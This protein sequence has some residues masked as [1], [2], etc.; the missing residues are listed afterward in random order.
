M[1][2]YWVSRYE[3]TMSGSIFDP[4][5]VP[6]FAFGGNELLTSDKLFK[7][8]TLHLGKTAN[9]KVLNSEFFLML[10]HARK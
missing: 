6:L 1:Y 2:L 10:Y 5:D 4:N 3:A 8:I 9:K 7:G